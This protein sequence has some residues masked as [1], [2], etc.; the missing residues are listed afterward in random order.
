MEVFIVDECVICLDVVPNR[1]FAPCGHMCCCESCAEEIETAK[2]PCPLCRSNITSV[3]VYTLDQDAVEAAPE[4]VVE[5]FKQNERAD[6]VKRLRPS[7]ARNAAFV[8]KNKFSKSVS[9]AIGDELEKRQMETRGTERVM[10]K[11]SA[12]V[13]ETIGDHTLVVKYK[14]GR[15]TW[16]ESQALM[17]LDDIRRD[18]RQTEPEELPTDNVDLATW[19]PDYYWNIYHLTDRKVSAFMEECGVSKRQRRR[20]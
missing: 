11:P 6:Y 18:F 1:T 19:Y 12:V 10:T 9:G 3:L 5:N 2:M 15:K 14:I 4:E 16:E 13:F 7:H 8:G 20:R 17:E